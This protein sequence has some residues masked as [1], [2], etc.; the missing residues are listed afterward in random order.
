MR[1]KYPLIADQMIQEELRK[2]P[3]YY[4]GITIPE[5]QRQKDEAIRKEIEIYEKYVGPWEGDNR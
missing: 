1:R 5:L 2:N 3:D 4:N